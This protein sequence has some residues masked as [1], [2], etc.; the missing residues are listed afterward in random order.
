LYNRNEAI[1][2]GLIIDQ[3]GIE[4]FPSLSNLCFGKGQF[5]TFESKVADHR[6]KEIENMTCQTNLC[7]DADQLRESIRIEKM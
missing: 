5:L 1:K 2:T 6:P 7:E 4:M 3:N